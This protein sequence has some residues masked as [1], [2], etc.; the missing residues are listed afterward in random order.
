M[1]KILHSADWHLDSP[2][3][4]RSEA[5]TA[6]LRAALL[7]LPGKIAAVCKAECCDIMLLAGDLFDGPY[8]ADSYH[9]LRS[10]LEEVAVPVFIA[11]GNHD[12]AGPDSPWLKERWPENVFIFSQNH[13]VSVALPNLNCWV[14]GAGF[15]ASDSDSLLE[16]FRAEDPT[17]LT[18]GVLHGDPTQTS[19]PYCPITEQQVQ[20]SGLDYLAL[21]HIH[22]GGSFRAGKTLCLWP[23]CPMGR[24]FDELGEKGV[25]IVTLDKEETSARFIPLDTPRFYDLEA[26]AG[27]APAAALNRILPAVG[28]AD[29]YRITLTGESEPLD[30]DGLASQFSRFPNL[31]IRDRTTPPIDLWACA[32]E[33][34]LEG[35]YFRMLQEA[36]DGQDEDTCNRI[37]LAAKISRQLLDGREVKLP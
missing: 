36:M 28:N 20:E 16:G 30:F 29:F 33:D 37:R 32:G 8:T 11:P 13:M 31:E 35:V 26:E 14:C 5:Q 7:A 19:S 2:I 10:A 17:F 34:T 12:F 27:D 15:T 21:G 1:I 6:L 24:G 23:G 25:Q 18:I 9:A 3:H 22:K 4:G